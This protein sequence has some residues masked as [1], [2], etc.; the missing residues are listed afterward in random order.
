MAS[1]STTGNDTSGKGRVD[2]AL[3]RALSS[4]AMYRGHP[5]VAVHETHASWVFVAGEYAYKIK[6]PLALGFLD[7][8]TLERRRSACHEEMRVNALL[9]P[10]LYLGVLAISRHGAG[11]RFVREGTPDAVEYAVEMASFREQDTLM[12]LIAAR[13]ITHAD[14]AAI[15]RFLADFHRGAAV[16]ADWGPAQ[17]LA[18][19]QRNVRELRLV[20][21][22]TEWQLDL[23]ASFGEAFVPSHARELQDRARAGLAR[24]GHGD[25]RCEHVL[26]KPSVRV[27][28][29]VEFD[30]G[31]RRT[32]VG[33]DLAFLTMDLEANGQRWAAQELVEVYESAG[34]SAGGQTLRA[35]Y[36]AHWALVRAKV[37]LIS[38]AEHGAAAKAEELQRA[39]ALWSLSERLSW[40]ARAPL[41]LVICGP[42]ASGKSTLAAE[43]SRRSEIPIV[44]SDEVRKRLAHIDPNERAGAEHYSQRFSHATY[45]QL[46]R[47]AQLALRRSASVIVDATC[48]SRADRRLLLDGLTSAG[49][50]RLIVRC[51]VPLEIALERAAR[52]LQDP[53]R[54]SDATPQVVEAQYSEF[55]EFDAQPDGSLLRLDTVQLLDQQIAE[56]T[57][58]VDRL[59]TAHA[60]TDP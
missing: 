53:E 44:S 11:F 1:T 12:G 42:Q 35:F 34:L 57:R 55:E 40:R 18:A 16:V 60:G 56:V 30:P 32:D 4:P 51:E 10:G 58:A 27:V 21:H 48:R 54:V 50:T 47:E 8:T 59:A 13:A 24:D 29:R 22:P 26:M 38:A 15:A 45:R 3:L 31:L 14:V 46:G 41:A 5:P 20:E 17:V 49:A 2:P 9:A 43:L 37:A 25:L 33:A 7:Y 36:A 52:R 39:R 6:K 19:W 28:D 23:A